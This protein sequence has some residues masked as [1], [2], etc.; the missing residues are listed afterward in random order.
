MSWS[1][2]TEAGEGGSGGSSAYGGGWVDDGE[3]SSQWAEY[4]DRYGASS[5]SLPSSVSIGSFLPTYNGTDRGA[6]RRV[7]YREGSAVFVADR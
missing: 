7:R 5:G 3:S 4:V 2:S 6:R 1:Q